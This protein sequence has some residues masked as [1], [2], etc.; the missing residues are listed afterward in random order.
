MADNSYDK[1]YDHNPWWK[2]EDELDTAKRLYE[3]VQ[4]I[5]MQQTGRMDR[6][7][8]SLQL[9]GNSDIIASTPYAY[10]KIATPVLPEN[11]V[12][13]NI[14]SSMC[15]TV[16][17][18]IAKM[19]PRVSFLTSGGNSMAQ[20]QAKKLSKFSDGMFYRN[21]VYQLHKDMFRDATVLDIGALKHYISE[22]EICTERVLAT[23]LVTDVADSLYGRPQSLYQVKYMEKDAAIALF[24]KARAA[25]QSSA[26]NIEL[27]GY[28][29]KTNSTYVVIIEAW[30]LPVDKKGT[31]GRHVIAVENGVCLDEEWKKDYFPFT[32]MRWAP[33]IYGFWGQSLADRLMGNQI[34]INKM[35]RI[36]QKS[37]HL[38]STFK[39]FLEY[40]S[41]V[42]K[43]HLNNEIGSIVYY[44]GAKPDYYVPK[45]VS[46]EY[47]RHLDW[48]IQKSYEEAGISEMSA[49]SI[50]PAGL[51]S[52]RALREYQDIQTNRFSL[53]A[54]LYEQTFLETARQYIELAK[55]LADE[56]IDFEVVAQSKKFIESIKWSEV[57]LKENDYIMQMFPVS[58]L[59]HEPA[60]RLQFVQEL[61]QS[62]MITPDFGLQLLDFPDLE[63]YMSLKTAA[64][65][66]LMATLS[67]ILSKGEYTPPEPEQDLVNGVKMFQ[68]AYLRGKNDKTPTARLELVLR[69]MSQAQAMLDRAAS[70]AQGQPG[71]PQPG[72]LMDPGLQ[73]GPGA[74]PE[75]LAPQ[76]IAPISV[77]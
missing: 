77:Q 7:L 27:R 69:W 43:E 5:N 9:Y 70:A 35:L 30:H 47:F 59:P 14:I 4:R 75:Q 62:G 40:G 16:S 25:I 17:A 8:R 10:A 64:V 31:F 42:A 28:E 12:K 48:L 6:N 45:V 55:E 60:G 20:D 44:T 63:S 46:E 18:Q 1:Q 52:G 23:E 71:V 76:P 13:V 33:Q 65:E 26:N 72:P 67:N 53:V 39:V 66:D 36:I 57:K 56:G 73:A 51:D 32:F 37:F 2:M 54:Q 61:M 74:A 3:T 41:K 50:K 38:G 21:D 29:P 24:P 34:E 15:D 68:S 49:Q 58:M 22:G 11:R 19:K